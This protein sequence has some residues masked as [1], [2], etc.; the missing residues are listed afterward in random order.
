[1][2]GSQRQVLKRDHAIGQHS[3]E[4]VPRH[5]FGQEE[6]S[7]VTFLVYFQRAWVGA[8]RGRRVWA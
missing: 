7:R 5:D 3:A 4:S 8:R 6:Q 1:M 2:P